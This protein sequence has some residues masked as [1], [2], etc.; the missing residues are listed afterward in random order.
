MP[1]VLPKPMFFLAAMYFEGLKAF[2]FFT[3][4]PFVCRMLEPFGREMFKD[5]NSFHLNIWTYFFLPFVAVAKLFFI[6]A[7]Y[8]GLIYF[9]TPQPYAPLIASALYPLISGHLHTDGFSDVMDAIHALHKDVETVI[10][11][12]H[13]GALG[14]AYSTSLNIFTTISLALCLSSIT[15]GQYLV[16]SLSVALIY[17]GTFSLALNV[18]QI[19]KDGERWPLSTV[20]YNVFGLS[21]KQLVSVCFAFWFACLVVCC[22]WYETL[23]PV[24][25]VISSLYVATIT[26][27]VSAKLGGFMNG[28]LLGFHVSLSEVVFFILAGIWGSNL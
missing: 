21:S 22:M 3:T 15:V 17:L 5:L 2:A 4:F 9:D 23:L 7:A 8:Q 12:P 6:F 27:R 11:D 10:Y 1:I 25:G 19:S 28:D 18:E 24:A 16:F 20:P 26:H 13:V 14:A